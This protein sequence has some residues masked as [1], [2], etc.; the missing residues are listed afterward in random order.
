MLRQIQY[1]QTLHAE[2]IIE[3]ELAQIN[4]TLKSYKDTTFKVV[5]NLADDIGGAW[6]NYYAT[7]YTS[8]FDIGALV[9]AKLL[10]T[11]FMDQ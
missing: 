7:N 9:E 2:Q 4:N 5:L 1:L 11:S 3:A 8:K 10:C 6:S